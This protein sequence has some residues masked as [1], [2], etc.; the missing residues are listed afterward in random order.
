MTPPT[1]AAAGATHANTITVHPGQTVTISIGL[2]GLGFGLW[3]FFNG[4]TSVPGGLAWFIVG[5]TG[6][7]AT[8]AVR[9][10]TQD[11]T[12]L[13]QSI[14]HGTAGAIT[15]GVGVV[16]LIVGLMSWWSRGTSFTGSVSWLAVGLSG[17]GVAGALVMS[18]L[19][20]L[21]SFVVGVLTPLFAS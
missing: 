20:A 13:A 3:S 18:L 8:A 17:G 7:G 9:E 4:R 10:L 19:V 5:M 1:L 2:I 6:V 15:L 14:A 12:T 21:F 16:A 11:A